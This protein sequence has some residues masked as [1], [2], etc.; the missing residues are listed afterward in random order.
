MPKPRAYILRFF[1]YW[2]RQNHSSFLIPPQIVRTTDT[3]IHFTFQGIA[4]EIWGYL[5]RHSG[6]TIGVN[7]KGECWDLLFEIDTCETKTAHGYICSLCVP[8]HQVCY[9]TRRDLWN[10]HTFKPF[11]TWCNETLAP[12]RWL[13]LH[14]T[15]NRGI[16][17]VKLSNEK[18]DKTPLTDAILLHRSHRLHIPPK[19]VTL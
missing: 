10:E 11:L 3:D 9:A 5:N 18:P 13:L 4:G 1:K 7:W 6:L 15:E 12:A 2:L 8:P 16:T 19:G 17:W 14:Q